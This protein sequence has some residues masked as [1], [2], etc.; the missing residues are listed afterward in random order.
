MFDY[1]YNNLDFKNIEHLACTEIRAAN[2]THCSFISA[3]EQGDASFIRVAN[4]HRVSFIPFTNFYTIDEK[5]NQYFN[6][7]KIYKII[8]YVK[9]FKNLYIF[10]L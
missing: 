9:S 8:E 4:T 7:L 10:F 6:Y 5:F 1:C 3:L 2:L